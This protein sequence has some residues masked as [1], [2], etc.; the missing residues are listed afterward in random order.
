MRKVIVSLPTAPPF[1]A[2]ELATEGYW[3]QVINKD[4]DV[5]WHYEGFVTDIIDLNNEEFK[6]KAGRSV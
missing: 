1:E 2:E 4:L 3:V 6:R 5:S